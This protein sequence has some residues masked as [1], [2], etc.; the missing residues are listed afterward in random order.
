MRTIILEGCD[1][2]GNGGDGFH[3]QGA[4]EIV[5]RNNRSFAN[6]GHGFV[7]IP[8]E[9]EILQALD[10]AKPSAEQSQLAKILKQAMDKGGVENKDQLSKHPAFKALV[11]LGHGSTALNQI[12]ELAESVW[13][14]FQRM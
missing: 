3:L 10:I 2:W 4:D 5:S 14:L 13:D 8:T 12:S 1:A 6:R 7:V 11:S 9:V